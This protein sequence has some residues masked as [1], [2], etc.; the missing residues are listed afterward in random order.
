M[1]EAKSNTTIDLQIDPK[2][3]IYSNTPFKVTLSLQMQSHLEK[4]HLSLYILGIEEYTKER[5]SKCKFYREVIE[6]KVVSILPNTMMSYMYPY[7]IERQLP[8]SFGFSGTGVSGS[9]RYEVRAKVKTRNGTRIAKKCV[10]I[11]Y[12]SYDRY[13]GLNTIFSK[14]AFNETIRLDVKLDKEMYR[15]DEKILCK[16]R[17][18]KR[19][20]DM[21]TGLSK[22]LVRCKLRQTL[23]I[24]ESVFHFFNRSNEYTKDLLEIQYTAKGRPEY[25]NQNTIEFPIYIDLKVTS[26]AVAIE[27]S[28]KGEHLENSYSLLFD[29]RLEDAGEKAEFVIPL[30][31]TA[32]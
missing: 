11:V 32:T 6:E 7:E 25:L 13:Y 26:L 10:D 21:C 19:V 23:T 30:L 8:S 22:A 12:C 20:W 29:L 27:G 9:I 3:L 1:H 14:E 5:L 24:K 18:T 17:I 15:A 28:T 16:C 4:S 2:G 31:I